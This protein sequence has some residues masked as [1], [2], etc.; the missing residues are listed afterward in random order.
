MKRLISLAL[1]ALLAGATAQAQTTTPH[2][3]AG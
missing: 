2:D 3:S 1:L